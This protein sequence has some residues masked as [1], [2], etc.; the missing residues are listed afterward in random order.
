MLLIWRCSLK[1]ISTSHAV[2][3]S[4]HGENLTWEP[5]T[6]TKESEKGRWDFCSP[7]QLTATD[8][9][10]QSLACHFIH[11]PGSK[12]PA[13]DDIHSYFPKV[14]GVVGLSWWQASAVTFGQVFLTDFHMDLTVAGGKKKKCGRKWIKLWNMTVGW[15]CGV[16]CKLLDSSGKERV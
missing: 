6:L 1:V 9:R 2:S 11:P 12:M 5:F 13:V 10:A 16:S 3:A 14:M 4:G 8:S 7:R 15:P